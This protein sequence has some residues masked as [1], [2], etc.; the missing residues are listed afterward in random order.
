MTTKDSEIEGLLPSP[1]ELPPA[2]RRRKSESPQEI[3]DLLCQD[4]AAVSVTQLIALV[5]GKGSRGR[6][7]GQGPQSW[8]S[9]ELAAELLAEAGGRLSNLVQATCAN[10]LDWRPFGVGKNIGARLIAAM[11]LAERWRMG[12]GMTGAPR[13]LSSPSCARA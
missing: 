9:V 13:R 12:F 4:P 8:S 6:G 10:A 2:K 1:E 11:E 7:K 3:R 5:L